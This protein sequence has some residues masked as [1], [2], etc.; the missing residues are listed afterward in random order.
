MKKYIKYALAITIV[1]PM[2]NSCKKFVEVDPRGVFVES[3]YYRDE[4]EAF[5]G[6]IAA[7][8][9]VGYQSGNYVTKVSASDAA[10]DEAYAGG[11]GSS[12]VPMLQ[13]VSNYSVNA[14]TGPQGDL[15]AGGFQGIYRA[16]ILLSKLPGVAM[17]DA[18]KARFTAEAKVLRAYFYFDLVRWF[19]NVPLIL[20]PIPREKAYDIV[21]ATPLAVYAQIEKDLKEAIADTN[22]PNT[23][24]LKT[25][26]GR[27]TKGIA[28]ALLGKVYL[29][30][31]KYTE[32]AA[33]L[34]IVNGTTPGQANTTYGY[35]LIADFAS[36]WKA[37]NKFNTESILEITHT[38]KSN[39]TWDCVACTEGNL[40]SI[41][42][43]PRDYSILAG[44]T[45]PD[46]I[47]GY[48]ILPAT[49]QIY[50]AFKNDPRKA[51]S[52]AD[53]DSLKKAGAVTYGEAYQGQGYHIGKFAGRTSD[54]T[55]GGGTDVLNYPQNMYEIRLADTYLME[56]EAIIVGGG[57]IA[58]ATALITAIRN[59]AYADGLQ[60]PV[61][62]TLANIMTERRLELAFEGHR[63][64]DLVRWGTAPQALAFKGFVAG[65][66]EILPVPLQELE[67]TKIKQSKEYG[68]TQ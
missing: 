16:N 60:H 28:H 1:L 51:S 57:N 44:K 19:K 2:L 18:V 3:Q 27:M 13:P 31:K 30:E 48:G 22:L 62:P 35:N 11:G 29:Y 68:G 34:A 38:S 5:N 43:A 17:S 64:F 47:A 25:E 9:I 65:K 53:L 20:E 7:Y 36:L 32:A 66:N 23:V 8:D 61:A 40:L 67:N 10:S 6:L 37:P 58:R 15:W 55:T 52:I 39:G 21:Q 42:V 46:Y 45:A 24:N 59:R 33:E 41:M 26:G 56:A 4:A 54:K 50:D 12:D 63:W 14:A 49:K